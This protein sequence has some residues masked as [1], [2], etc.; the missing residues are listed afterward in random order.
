M[1]PN[2]Q[3]KINR[4]GLMEQTLSNLLAQKQQFQAQ[5]IEVE[6]AL[7]ELEK[8]N[9]AYKIIGSIMV[10]SDKKSLITDLNEKKEIFSARVKV[11]EKQEQ[12]F[13]DQATKIQQELM[14]DS[15]K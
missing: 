15:K 12:Q 8:A 2:V 1:T 13:K 9:S 4:L 10:A 5:L 7:V 3:E 6:S 11:L 14:K